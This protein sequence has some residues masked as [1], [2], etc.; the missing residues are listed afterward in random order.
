[1]IELGRGTA[2]STVAPERFVARW[3]EPATWSEWDEDISSA[4]LK[5]PVVSGARGVLNPTS[6]PRLKFTVT[7]YDP[8]SEFTDT[9][10]LPGAR[11]TF[12]HLAGRSGSG[13]DLLVRITIE[14]LTSRVFAALL[15]K[16]FRSAAQSGLDRLVSLLERNHGDTL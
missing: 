2:T 11:L 14:G 5:G 8:S 4:R 13:T 15:S 9:T 3:A 12:R 1:M 7:G 16:Q 10:A 6:G